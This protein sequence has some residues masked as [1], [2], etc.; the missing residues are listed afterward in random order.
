MIP[1]HTAVQRT[2]IPLGGIYR[3]YIVLILLSVLCCLLCCI[4]RIQLCYYSTSLLSLSA[5]QIP[6]YLT[7]NALMKVRGHTGQMSTEMNG[8]TYITIHL[9]DLAIRMIR[10]ECTT[11]TVISLKS[12]QNVALWIRPSIDQLLLSAQG[13]ILQG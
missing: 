3:L 4:T 9:C 12:S 6:L 2:L 10:T 8:F 13:V 11:V 7:P 1:V 5:R